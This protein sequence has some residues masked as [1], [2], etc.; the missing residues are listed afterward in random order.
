M[1]SRHN[2]WLRQVFILCAA[3]ELVILQPVF[4]L[5]KIIVVP[6]ARTIGANR[7]QVDITHKEPLFD[8][9]ALSFDI[10]V[11]AGIG[12]R[13][14]LETKVPLQG[15][16]DN[17]LFFGKYTFAVASEARIALAVGIENVGNGSQAVPY[18]VSSCMFE[19]VDFTAG[20]AR[21]ASGVARFFTGID[22]QVGKRLHI[23]ADYNT[24]NHNTENTVYASAGFQY[25]FS[26][27]WSLKS[28]WEANR[29]SASDMMVKVAFSSNY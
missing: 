10:G 3:V 13:G 17:V 8:A 19:P 12:K 21:G 20:V 4:A 27:D 7:Y 14:Q 18:L 29:G 16:G 26:G 1:E 11:K 5:S 28:A 6:T 9:S 2:R 15:N 24:G 25:V 22:Y 23:L